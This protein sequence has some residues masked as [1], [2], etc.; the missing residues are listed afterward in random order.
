[1]EDNPKNE[2][3]KLL[4]EYESNRGMAA[5]VC[6]YPVSLMPQKEQDRLF[7]GFLTPG[8]LA[9]F[10]QSRLKILA[11]KELALDEDEASKVDSAVETLE[12]LFSL[13]SSYINSGIDRDSLREQVQATLERPIAE[14]EDGLV[15]AL[16][17]NVETLLFLS[18]Q[19]LDGKDNWDRMVDCVQLHDALSRTIKIC[20]ALQQYFKEESKS[21]AQSQS[22]QSTLELCQ[23]HR[24]TLE[25][26]FKGDSSGENL[27]AQFKEL[28]SAVR[29][30]WGDK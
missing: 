19:E 18:S 1:M 23:N 26:F 30:L 10:T 11:T 4:K 27:P 22:V 17:S 24:E 13:F 5:M 15:D 25:T 21:G 3:H 2:L 6:G 29:E 16:S 7:S 12:K 9:I 8:N 28:F 14:T 20:T